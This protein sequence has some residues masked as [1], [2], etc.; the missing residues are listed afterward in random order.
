MLGAMKGLRRCNLQK[1]AAC[2]PIAAVPG[3]YCRRQSRATTR[4]LVLPNIASIGK[5]AVALLSRR[6]HKDVD[7][8]QRF[9]RAGLQSVLVSRSCIARCAGH[10]LM[11]WESLEQSES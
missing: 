8:G 6:F 10:N 7:L 11:I 3:K 9:D 2:P 5:A 4:L 1:L